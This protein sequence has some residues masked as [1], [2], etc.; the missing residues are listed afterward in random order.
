[1]ANQDPEGRRQPSTDREIPAPA[2]REIREREI[3]TAEMGGERRNIVDTMDAAVK[4]SLAH[5]MHRSGVFRE[6]ETITLTVA[7]REVS[8][9]RERET[10]T[11]SV[12]GQAQ[13]P[14]AKE[15]IADHSGE[16]MEAIRRAIAA[17]QR[18]LEEQERREQ[19]K[20]AYREDRRSRPEGPE[21]R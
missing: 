12:D 4:K 19:R 18:E 13:T 5:A 3:K 9:T 15:F 6:N 2:P 17:R 20:E 11:T 10:V 16:L 7:G 1:M 8:V 14:Q 21:G